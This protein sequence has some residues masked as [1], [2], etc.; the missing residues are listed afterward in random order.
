MPHMSGLEIRTQTAG[1]GPAIRHLLLEA[2]DTALEADLVERLQED[3]DCVLSLVAADGGRV[4]GHIVFSR[5]SAPFPAAGLAPVA[6]AAS[7]RRQGIASRL[8][9][10][11]I[12]E[13]Q[14]RGIH[15]VFVL[16]DPAFYG[17]FGFSKQAAENYA[18]PYAGPYFMLL[19][20]GGKTEL[21]AS[22]AVNYAPAFAAFE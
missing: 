4:V 9:D 13:L 22:G 1:D 14:R 2:F 6:V 10:A 16:G 8:I 7:H 3:G 19:R 17:R 12:A 5:M 21:P 11:G 20:L 15:G 18:C